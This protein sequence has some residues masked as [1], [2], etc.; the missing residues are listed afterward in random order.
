MRSK[1]WILAT[2]VSALAVLLS[3][4]ARPSTPAPA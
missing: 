1:V 4:C 2:V 3:A